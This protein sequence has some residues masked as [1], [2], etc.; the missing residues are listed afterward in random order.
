MKHEITVD[1]L[2]RIIE[3]DHIVAHL[4]SVEYGDPQY[5]SFMVDLPIERLTAN[6][7]ILKHNEYEIGFASY[8]DYKNCWAL[9]RKELE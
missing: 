3:A 6:G 7:I 1:E 9:T 2:K 8:D 4:Y 5:D